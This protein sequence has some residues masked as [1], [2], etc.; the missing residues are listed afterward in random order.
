VRESGVV[1]SATWAYR[2]RGDLVVGG[3]WDCPGLAGLFNTSI[4]RVETVDLSDSGANNLTLDLRDLLGLESTQNT[5]KVT[6]DVDDMI[7]L[8]GG[9]SASASGETQTVDGTT[10]DV[11]TATTEGVTAEVWVDQTIDQVMAPPVL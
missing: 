1:G 8:T 9:F 7:T 11:Y 2:E 4:K 3:H 10:Y 5:L 6:G